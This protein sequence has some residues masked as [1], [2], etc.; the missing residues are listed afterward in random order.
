MLSCCLTIHDTVL[1]LPQHRI[2]GRHSQKKFRRQTCTQPFMVLLAWAN[3][4]RQSVWHAPV[5]SV[6]SPAR[7][8]Q[9][10]PARLSHGGHH[11][12]LVIQ[13]LRRLPFIAPQPITD[14]ALLCQASE[15]LNQ[16]AFAYGKH[17]VHGIEP[18]AC[19]VPLR[20][21]MTE[22]PPDEPQNG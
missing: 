14:G 11:N 16:P 2:E 12:A 15:L 7:L 22:P 19:H 8:S 4:N 17:D 10:K 6:E 13:A 1:K 20:A 3:A 9:V 5:F 18:N 21:R